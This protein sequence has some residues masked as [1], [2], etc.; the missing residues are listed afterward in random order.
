VNFVQAFLSGALRETAVAA[1][2]GVGETSDAFNLAWTIP[3]IFRRFVTDEG[4]TG[5]MIPALASADSDGG[6]AELGRLAASAYAA[7]MLAN[8]ALVAIGIALAQYLVLGFAPAWSDEPD[9]LHLAVTMT[10]WMFPMVALFSTVSYFEG[11]LNYRGHFFT[12]KFA[13]ALVSLGVIGAALFL[14]PYFPKP[15]YALVFGTVAG[16]V[17]H[18]L[19]NLPVLWRVWG[20]LGFVVDFS[21]RVRAVAVEMSKVLLIGVFAQINLVV[22]QQLATSLPAG[23][24]TIYRNSTQLTDLA[25]G[26]VAVAIGSALLPNISVSVSTRSWDQ[27]RDEL[28]RA[29]RLAAF[30]LI[31]AASVL[32]C[33]GTPVTAMLFRLGKYR[34]ED[35]QLTASALRLL[36]PF[37]LGVAGINIL[38]K[39]YFALERRGTL[40]AVGAFGVAL[41]AAC[42]WALTGPFGLHGLVASLSLSTALQLCLYLAIL[43]WSLGEHVG[44]RTLVIPLLKIVVATVPLGATLLVTVP[45][46]HWED[47]PLRATNWAVFFGGFAVAGL[48]YLLAATLLG[49]EEVSTV[50]AKL[51]RRV[52]R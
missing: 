17:A 41:T 27:F 43:W 6:A 46:G 32:L 29:L 35:V 51:R 31:P 45:L 50:L 16:G 20:R 48:V 12:P 2:L 1:F 21:P 42:G 3:N 15:V 8:V 26:I 37:V 40:L 33:Y 5:A 14:G 24:L 44:L 9:R 7:L 47:G 28:T 49:V 11:L 19:I 36:A 34:W 10:R 30:L 25:Q 18:A 4:L 52:R 22:L 38:K 13:P 39:V 23:S